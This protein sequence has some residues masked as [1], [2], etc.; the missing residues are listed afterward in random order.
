M[1]LA[2]LLFATIL[3][4]VYTHLAKNWSVNNIPSSV[5]YGEII[6]FFDSSP[7]S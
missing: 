6:F 2:V 3:V 4:L 5:E 7:F 1:R